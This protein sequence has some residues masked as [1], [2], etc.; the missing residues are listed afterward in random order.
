[1]CASL[2]HYIRTN[3]AQV[4]GDFVVYYRSMLSDHFTLTKRHLGILLF[5]AGIL[6]FIAIIGV[7]VLDVGREGGIGPAQQIALAA[8]ALVALIGLSLIPLGST[9]A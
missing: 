8:S 2:Y 4:A 6:A 9:P 1:M 3:T 7:D 5:A